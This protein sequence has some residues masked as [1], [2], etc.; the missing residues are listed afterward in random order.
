MLNSKRSHISVVDN[1]KQPCRPVHPLPYRTIYQELIWSNRTVIAASSAAVVG[2]VA[3]YPFDSIKTRMQT[4]PY[5]SITACVRQTYREEGV[6]GFFR[7]VLPPLVTVSIIKSISFSVY[8]ETKTFLKAQSPF[9]ARDD[10]LRSVMTRSTLGGAASGAFVATFS[11]PFEL[12]K[13]HKQLEILLLQAS[14]ISTGATVMRERNNRTNGG[15]SCNNLPTT[16]SWHSAKEIVR[17]KG[18]LG[19]WSGYGLH[20][21]RDTLGTAVYFGG[22]ETTKFLLSGPERTAGPMTQFLAGG[23]CGILCWLAVFPIDLVKSLMQK[24][25]LSPSRKYKSTMDCVKDIYHSRGASGFY[26]GITVTL[27]RAF[28][29][30]SLN[31]LVYE[32]TL[33]L[34]RYASNHTHDHVSL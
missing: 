25:V 26:R 22:Y 29:I 32:Q 20:F 8:E 14:S 18:I 9:Y 19:L 4:E 5:D 1:D 6:R 17:S 34:V 31:F 33:L 16:S 24:E 21:W 15:G 23:T 10:N 2:V 28:P 7:G 27:I 3:G 30:H 13:I 12:V 11:C